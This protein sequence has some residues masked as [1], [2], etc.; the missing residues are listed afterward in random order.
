M[1]AFIFY[2]RGPCLLLAVELTSASDGGRHTKLAGNTHKP[3]QSFR[4]GMT[5]G[6][7][8]SGLVAKKTPASLRIYSFGPGMACRRA[9]PSLD[10]S[11]RKFIPLGRKIQVRGVKVKPWP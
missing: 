7:R 6:T 9:D 11:L 4:G 10:R 3:Q 8:G 1:L 5:C 2:W